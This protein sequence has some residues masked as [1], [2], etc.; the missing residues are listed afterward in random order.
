MNRQLQTLLDDSQTHYRGRQLKKA[1]NTAQ[2]ALEFGLN[3]GAENMGLIHANLLLARIYNTNGRYQNEPA[4][5]SKALYYLAEAR[6]LNELNSIFSVDTEINLIGGKIHLNLKNYE[7]AESLLKRSLELANEQKDLKGI[8]FSQATLSQLYASRNEMEKAVQI[9][10]EGLNFLKKN[11]KTNHVPLWSEIYL[12]LSQAYIKNKDYSLSLEMSQHLLQLSRS[13]GDVEK[14]VLALKNIAVVCGVKSNYKIGM[15]YFLEALD[16]CEAIGYRELLTQIQINVGTLYA[17]LFNYEEAIKR[18]QSVLKEHAE[19]LDDRTKAAVFNNLGNIYFTTDRLKEALENFEKAHA[20]AEECQF[21]EMIAYALAQLSRTKI[22]LKMYKA[23]AEDAQWAAELFEKLGEINGIQINL[24]NLG[25]LAFYEKKYAKAVEMTGRAIEAAFHLKDDAAEI[26]SLKLLSAIY[27]GMGEFEKALEYQERYAEIQEEFAKQQRNRQFLDMEIRHAIREQQKEIEQ[28]T[29]ENEYKS[30]LLQKSDQ[31]S[32]QNQE[33]LRANEE[34]RQFAYVASHDLKEPLRMIGSYTQIIQRITEKHPE[35]K[36]QQ[37]FQFVID[38]VQ[39]MNNLLD[40]LLRY[41]TIGNSK[42]EMEAVDLNQVMQICLTN[43]KIR[44]EE[45]KADIL[46]EK[47]PIVR[48]NSQL[49]TQLFQNLLGNALKFIQKDTQPIVN[50]TAKTTE[51]SHVISITDNGI[52][53]SPEHQQRIFE[54]FHRLHSRAEYEGT[55]IG[56]S[57]CQKIAKCHNGFIGVRSE[58]GQGATF[59]LEIPAEERG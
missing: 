6:R 49:L 16:K 31:I 20:I 22:S 17:H 3:E 29:K 39:R 47:M 13:A 37:Y 54:I 41:A 42:V 35:D 38:G 59:Y 46:L 56:L 44:I 57:I 48:G 51:K 33:L 21:P 2:I 43:L 50:I 8:V 11:V 12:A 27:K 5:L 30:L 28:L 26:R 32:R 52:G 23:A 4:F 45:T 9:A 1:L 10:E 19:V 14:E 7:Q 58:E 40:G 55:G 24:L 36:S 18:Y 34:L 15:Q 25:S 53:I